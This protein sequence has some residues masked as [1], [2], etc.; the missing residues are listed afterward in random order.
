MSYKAGEYLGNP[1][2]SGDSVWAVF[3]DRGKGLT[4]RLGPAPAGP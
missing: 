3:S 4:A 2:F 1:A